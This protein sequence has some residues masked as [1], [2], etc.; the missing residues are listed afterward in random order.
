MAE[1]F[2]IPVNEFFLLAGVFL[3]VVMLV[4]GVYGLITQDPAVRRMS[5]GASPNPGGKNDSSIFYGDNQ[6]KLL[7][8]LYPLQQALRKGEDEKTRGL[9]RTRLIQ[10]GFYNPH[11]DKIYFLIRIGLAV[12]LSA[13]ATP[14][15]FYFLPPVPGNLVIFG[16]VFAA[17][18]GY[19]GPSL[20]LTTIISNRQQ[21]FR[22]GMPDALDMMLVG[23]ESGMS[24]PAAL[25]QLCEELAEAHPVVCE[26]F[27][28][29]GL[30]F[31]AGKSRAEAL[32]S[33]AR[34]VDVDEARTFAS[35]ITQSEALGTSLAQTLRVIADEMR[36][37]R[38]LKAEKTATELPVKMAF[39]LVLFIF[40]ALFMTIM[41]PVLIRLAEAFDSAF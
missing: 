33:L 18:I 17:V 10:A 25:Q 11:T 21:E 12:F 16:I 39:P 27:Q 20:A 40:P 24:L 35:M 7:R 14:I 19:F 5:D 1:I 8:V 26:Q 32:Q 9:I 4:L 41:A 34:R 29:V 3:V 36:K 37:D 6:L 2:G 38:L 28:I 23:I 13:V 22:L 15:L 31:Q 30:E